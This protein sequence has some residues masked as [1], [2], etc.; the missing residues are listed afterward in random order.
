MNYICSSQID[1]ASVWKAMNSRV[2]LS[3]LF[4][5]S[6]ISHRKEQAENSLAEMV[7]QSFGHAK[8]VEPLAGIRDYAHRL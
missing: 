4:A 3:G 5:M 1:Q 2:S 8:S 7:K 6:A